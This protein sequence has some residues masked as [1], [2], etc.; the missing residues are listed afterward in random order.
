M[1]NIDPRLLPFN[2]KD[3]GIGSFSEKALEQSKKLNLVGGLGKG[4][5][6]KSLKS[7]FPNQRNPK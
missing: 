3:R 2:F 1:K 5:R 7:A 6:G 4:G